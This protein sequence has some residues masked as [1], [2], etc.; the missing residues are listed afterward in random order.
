MDIKRILL[1]EFVSCVSMQYIVVSILHARILVGV[2]SNIPL[3]THPREKFL[4]PCMYLFISDC[5]LY[6]LF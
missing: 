1:L 6:Y 2:G 3:T 4:D 5:F